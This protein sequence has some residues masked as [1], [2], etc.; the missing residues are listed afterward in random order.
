MSEY[1]IDAEAD[2]V[3]LAAGDEF[4]VFQASSGRIKKATLAEV[5]GFSNAPV[6][7]TA[8]VTA[9]ALTV[10]AHANRVVTLNNT[11]P[12]AVTLPASA[13]TGAKFMLVLQVS[14]TAT[15]ST[16]KVANS[17]DI[18]QGL[19]ISLNTVAGTVIGFSATSTS[20]TVTLNGTTT[21]GMIG[22]E[23][24]FTD[25]KTGFWLLAGRDVAPMT[26]TPMSATV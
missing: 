14:A 5:G 7:V 24:E 2:V 13:G 26:T 8:G 10:A 12:I 6:N 1:T 4:D 21:G 9:L 18:M 17:T 23:Y 19:V 11:A 3:T 16:I 20:D 25:I 15:Q 22:G